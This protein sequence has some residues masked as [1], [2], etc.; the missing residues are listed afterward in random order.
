M[1]ID[2]KTCIVKDF[3]LFQIEKIQH[4]PNQNPPSLKEMQEIQNNLGGEGERR[5][6]KT[7]GL[8]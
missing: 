8:H 4:N 1:L 7:L 3:K 5:E 6:V 2:Y